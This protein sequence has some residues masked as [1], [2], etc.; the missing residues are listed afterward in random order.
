MSFNEARTE[1]RSS[2]SFRA[3]SSRSKSFEVDFLLF[4]SVTLDMTIID[5]NSVEVRDAYDDYV[6]AC[7][8]KGRVVLGFDTW[9]SYHWNASVSVGAV[10]P[11]D[12]LPF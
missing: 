2:S 9:I 1:S 11:D 5:T 6:S 7:V 4:A 12:D 8:E 3:I 10:D